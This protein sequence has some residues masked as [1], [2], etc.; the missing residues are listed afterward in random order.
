MVYSATVSL[1]R[2]LVRPMQWLIRRRDNLVICVA[3]TWAND[4]MV[5]AMHGSEPCYVT[6]T[7]SEVLEEFEV[8]DG[9]S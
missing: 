6:L 7:M 8:W 4:D 3:E 1:N 5:S 9:S 2:N